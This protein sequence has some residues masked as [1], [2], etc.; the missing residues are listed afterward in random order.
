MKKTSIKDVAQKAGVSTTLVS[1]VLNGK[2]EG[3]I[4]KETAE[5]IR[6]A[7]QELNYQPSSIAKSLKLQRTF[8]IGLVVADISNSFASYLARIMEDE[9][10]KKG[11]TLLIGSSDENSQKSQKLIDAFRARQVDG[12]V[13]APASGTASQI[14]QLLEAGIPTV[15]IDRFFPELPD[16]SWV[17]INNFEA[18]Y[19]ATQHLLASG[20][21]HLAIVA[22][23]TDLFHLNERLKGF[24]K[25]MTEEGQDPK[26][27][28]L[29]RVE[30]IDQDVEAAI[31][32]F[33]NEGVKAD[34]IFFTSNKLAV[35]GLKVLIKKHI[36]V[37]DDVAVVAFDETDAYD[38]FYS[39]LTYVQQPLAQIGSRAIEILTSQIESKDITPTQAVFRAQLVVRD[40]SVFEPV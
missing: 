8:T 22:Y 5:K 24:E 17:S 34:S 6:T 30:H 29:V 16:S 25:A 32:K 12:F 37:P 23:Q 10:A 14:Q 19:E 40:S 33:L 36:S 27:V 26:R 11:Y 7:A 18:S 3:R 13:I 9:A 38:L 28:G 31:E 20:R 1:Y 2:M 39:P 21:K 4:G 35:S 15:L